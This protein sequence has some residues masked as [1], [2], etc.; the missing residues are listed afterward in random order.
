MGVDRA[1]LTQVREHVAAVIL[2]PHA[3]VVERVK[4]SSGERRSRDRQSDRLIQ[5]LETRQANP[6]FPGLIGMLIAKPP[7]TFGTSSERRIVAAVRHKITYNHFT[8]ICHEY[9]SP[10]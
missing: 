6:S 9:R 8:L 1:L 2:V 10:L 3:G 4:L 5:P 7:S